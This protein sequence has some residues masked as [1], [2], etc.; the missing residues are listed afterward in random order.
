MLSVMASMRVELEGYGGI[1][2]GENYWSECELNYTGIGRKNVRQTMENLEFTSELDG[3]VSV[4]FAGSVDPEFTTGD[5]CIIDSVNSAEEERGFEV[6]SR[7]R[8]RAKL[9]LGQDAKFCE[10]LTLEKP[11][12]GPGEKKDLA[13]SSYSIIDQETYWVAKVVK[14]NEVPFLAMRVVFDDVDTVLPPAS[15]YDDYGEVR[16]PSLL[17]WLVKHPSIILDTPSLFLNSLG[18]RRKLTDALDSVIPALLR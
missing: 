17:S 3:V 1:D 13:G 18:A 16:I 6:D 14:E 11:A 5:L 10:L 4:G 12:S 7:L 2:E 9:A 15:C 8:E